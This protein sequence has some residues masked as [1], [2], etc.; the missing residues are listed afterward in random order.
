[1]PSVLNK[2]LALHREAPRIY[3]DSNLLDD[4]I[5]DGNLRYDRDW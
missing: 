2:T 4:C 5:V 1:M 3:I